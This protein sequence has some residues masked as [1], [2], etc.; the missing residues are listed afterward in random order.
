MRP[1]PVSFARLRP[2]LSRERSDIFAPLIPYQKSIEAA[3][4][5]AG[6]TR[7]AIFQPRHLPKDRATWPSIFHQVVGNGDMF[8][9]SQ[10][11]AK[12]PGY[13]STSKICLVEPY[14]KK[15]IPT[16]SLFG[17]TSGH[18]FNNDHNSQN[19]ATERPVDIDYTSV[20]CGVRPGDVDVVSNDSDLCSAV[21]PYAYN[22]GLLAPQFYAKGNGSV[23]VKIRNTNT[24]TLVHSTF[25]VK[26]RQAVVA[27]NYDMT[28][29]AG[30]GSTIRLDF[31]QPY[32]NN[33]GKALPTGRTRDEVL[34]FRVSCVD[35]V[36]PAVFLRADDLGIDG[37]ILP[38]D[39]EK[40]YEKLDLLERIRKAAAVAMGIASGEHLVP[41]TIPK[42]GLVSQSTRHFVL[43][44]R[45]LA[46]SQTD[47]I[48]RFL[49]GTHVCRA[50]PLEAALTTAVAARIPGTL[51]EQMLSPDLVAPDAITVGHAAGR[52]QIITTT[53]AKKKFLPVNVT[54]YRTAKRIFHGEVF[55]TDNGNVAKRRH[56]HYS[57]SGDH[58]L[59]LAFVMECRGL[60]S[61]HLFEQDMKGFQ[62]D[63]K[64]IRDTSALTSPDHQIYSQGWTSLSHRPTSLLEMTDADAQ[65]PEHPSTPL[66][67]AVLQLRN[68]LNTLLQDHELASRPHTGRMVAVLNESY[69]KL[70]HTPLGATPG[71]EWHDW[72]KRLHKRNERL[73]RY[74]RVS[75]ARDLKAS[76]G[77]RRTTRRELGLDKDGNLVGTDKRA[78][79]K[80]AKNPGLGLDEQDVICDK[81]EHRSKK[82]TLRRN[83]ARKVRREHE[84]RERKTDTSDMTW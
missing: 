69:D 11:D 6:T 59:G 82:Q 40:L 64:S 25:E 12:G 3:Y 51:V 31:K 44:G 67:T 35:G 26:A 52:V 4:Y 27:E 62:M 38:N 42:I 43:S 81:A 55:Y 84:A 28:E 73:R 75:A 15:T 8:H 49:S 47:V 50:I 80:L 71:K 48:L 79:Q 20:E 22:A 63:R 36:D 32:G 21:G 18:V 83:T 33:T 54:V 45:K 61:S 57:D 2:Y 60:S 24:G 10:L 17:N 41:R 7:A 37:T 74:V 68:H 77:F 53:D 14:S 5:R 29:V 23:T 39:F 13:E 70:N 78:I 56:R 30:P 34:G 9:G 58:S 1:S 46:P 16:S 65:Y 66:T 19:N 72:A 76:L